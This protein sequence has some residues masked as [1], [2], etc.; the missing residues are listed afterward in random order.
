MEL[1]AGDAG[2]PRE[3]RAQHRARARGRAGRRRRAGLQPPGLD[4]AAQPR[5][6]AAADAALAA[7][8]RVLRRARACDLW[9][10][11]LHGLQA[12]ARQLDQGRWT[13]AAETASV[14]LGDAR[15]S[16]IPRIYARRRARPRAR[17]PRRPGLV[18]RPRRAARALAEL[19]E[20]LQR[21]EAGRRGAA[22]RSPGCAGDRE[23]VAQATEAAFAL[24]QRAAAPAGVVG[25]LA[26]VAPAR[27]R[28][29]GDPGRRGRALRAASS[30]ATGG[31]P[32]PTV[33]G[34]RA[35]RT[36]RRWRAADG[37]DDALRRALDRAAGARR[38][39]R[40]R[41]SSPGACA[42][43]ARAG[44]RA[45]PRRAT[46]GNPAEPDA[47]RGRGAGARRAGAAQ[48][49]DRRAARSSRPRRSTT[50]SARSCASSA[51]TRAARRAR[52]PG[53]S[54]VGAGQRLNACARRPVGAPGGSHWRTMIRR[55]PHVDRIGIEERAAWLGKRS[56]KTS[57][58]LQGIRLAVSM[59]DLTTLE[60]QDTAGKVRQLA[61]KAVC[62][63]PTIPEIP[64][65]RRRLRLSGAGRRRPRRAR[66]HRR[67]HRRGVDRLP[68]RADVAGD[69]AAGDRGGGRRRRRRDRH[70]DL[71]RGLPLR[72]RRARRWRRS[73][74]SRRRAATRT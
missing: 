43:A 41:R 63:A 28:L 33:D 50:T 24:A 54:G 4:G 19:S 65:V 64:S 16:S 68:G 45:G 61:A 57:A 1:L 56:I 53:G 60:G 10:L 12:P 22:P 32:R 46:R 11:Y 66:G 13:E 3:A 18:G 49:A 15:T 6:Y 51:S 34:D 7:G 48:H 27:G 38:A 67:A 17:A 62:P 31:A 36:R 71:A 9:R 29:R 55:L 70:G 20:E 74:A 52:P 73:C 23:G 35:A 30:P 58:K 21:I 44:C 40:P 8:L 72:R 26:L 2:G 14:V 39:A 37:D 59:V 69:Q 25:E 42:H 47:A 5:S